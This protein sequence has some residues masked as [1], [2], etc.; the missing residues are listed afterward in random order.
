MED[1]P[2]PRHG[3]KLVALA[4][5]LGAVALLVGG[6]EDPGIVAQI[7]ESPETFAAPASAPV[8]AIEQP[9]RRAEPERRAA[10]PALDAWYAEATAVA[11]QTPAPEA[12]A[13]ETPAPID[14]RHLIDDTRPAVTTE[15]IG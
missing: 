7:G 8:A 6:E 14:E 10:D 12:P 5:F 13:P 11:P 2:I 3:K 4:L 9:V 1:G 15:P